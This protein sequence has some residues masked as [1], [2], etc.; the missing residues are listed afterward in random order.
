LVDEIVL[1]GGGRT[2]ERRN[3]IVVMSGTYEL[4]K[5]LMGM[6]ALENLLLS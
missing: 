6:L 3:G 5:E 2:D 4:E 1:I